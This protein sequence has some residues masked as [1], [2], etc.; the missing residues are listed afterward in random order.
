MYTFEF[1]F[2]YNTPRPD[3]NFYMTYKSR[4]EGQPVF[5]SN[6]LSQVFHETHRLLCRQQVLFVTDGQSLPTQ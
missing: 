2:T 6:Y 4:L 5:F 3:N 1:F